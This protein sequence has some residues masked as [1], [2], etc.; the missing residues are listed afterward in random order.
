MNKR[1]AELT[2]SILCF[3]FIFLFYSTGYSVT[4]ADIRARG[5]LHHLGVPYARFANNNADGLDCALMRRFAQHLG[6]RYAFIPTTWEKAIPDLTGRHLASLNSEQA[7]TPVHGDILASGISIIPKR[8]RRVLFSKPTFTAQVWLI[9]KP[10][11]NITP[12][13]P[14]G[15]VEKDI[16]IT[17]A[18]TAGKTVYG[19]KD[20]CL[21]VRRFP[22]LLSTASSAI[23]VSP[24]QINEPI[25]FLKSEYSIFLMESPSA[26]MALGIWPYSFKIIGPVA[27]QQKMGAAFAP[28]SVELRDEFNRFFT[29]FWESGEYQKLVHRYYPSSYLYFNKFFMKSSP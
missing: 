3:L 20:V 13:Q 14:T 12:I 16:A 25:S 24:Q 17:L 27:K 23:N 1:H 8:Q 22:S 10:E 21:D 19:I 7:T 2:T 9:A 29:A 6:V 4:L 28:E 5:E 26:L 11:V 15:T 18:Q